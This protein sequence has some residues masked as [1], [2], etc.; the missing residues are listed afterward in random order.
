MKT[1]VTKVFSLTCDALFLREYAFTSDMLIERLSTEIFFE[2][3]DYLT[4]FEIFRAFI[5]LN[6]RLNGILG[7]YPMCL[8]FQHLSRRKF[9]FICR[10][11]QPA[12]V[13]AI[14]LS[15]ERMPNQ[16]MLFKRHFPLFQDDFVR[17]KTLRFQSTSTILPSLPPSTSSLEIE[18][19]MKAHETD[20]HI[21]Q[22]LQHCSSH[23]TSLKV[24][25][26]YVFRSLT[27]P[28]PRLS[29]LSIGFC[30]MTDLQ[31]LI[32]LLT[33]SLTHLKLF[34][35]QEQPMP[36]LDFRHLATSLTHLTLTLSKSKAMTERIDQNV[37]PFNLGLVMS[38]DMVSHYLQPLCN[39]RYLVVQAVGTLDL[40]NGSSWEDY[41]KESSIETFHFKFTLSTPWSSGDHQAVLLQP[42]RS[43]FWLEKKDWYVACET[44]HFQSSRPI[45]YSLPYFQSSCIV[46]PL[47]RYF[48]I[49]G[50]E[51]EVL[52][53][54]SIHL[55]ITYYRTISFPPRPFLH[56]HSL[57]LLTARLPAIDL[58][59]SIT[60]LTDIRCL[61]ISLIDRVSADE[62][63]ILLEHMP[64][65]EH[66]QMRFDPLFLSPL[67]IASFN[68][69]HGNDQPYVV[70]AS[71]VDRFC[72]LF[73]Y[74]KYLEISVQSKQIIIQL[75]N[76]LHYLE[77]LHLSCYEDSLVDIGYT[78]LLRHIP[79]LIG[80]HFSYRITS[81]HLTLSIGDH[82]VSSLFH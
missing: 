66:V 29:H 76:R 52:Q 44:G 13:L 54:C 81:N 34:V 71:N 58:L 75:L 48:S 53:R 68:I 30:T 60:N 50:A 63:Y 12:Q 11:L 40:M 28:F 20:Y 37:S 70:N 10:Y 19:F 77:L 62:L 82:R 7:L 9:D 14:V 49:S 8:D 79:R 15:D 41:L 16:C 33:S 57:T 65:L 21:V 2:I 59:Q 42:F 39:L 26:S 36:Q 45:L 22:L 56:V 67:K 43:S 25:G 61:D 1:R 80:M 78:W 32:P 24:D 38:F 51:N 46:Y 64:S 74:L 27:A 31:H 47:K 6:H 18:T 35:D 4:P 73:F 72:Y 69:T 5:N 17:L 55:I 3:F 23:L